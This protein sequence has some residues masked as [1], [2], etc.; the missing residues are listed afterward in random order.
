MGDD[1]M[2]DYEILKIEWWYKELDNGNGWN[3]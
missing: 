3:A 1:C 2:L